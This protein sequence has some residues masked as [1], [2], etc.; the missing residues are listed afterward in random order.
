MDTMSTMSTTSMM[1]MPDTLFK[2]A[3]SR[4]QQSLSLQSAMEAP[5]RGS[6]GAVH[7][8]ARGPVYIDDGAV[9]RVPS[10]LH[11]G[12]GA[13]DRSEEETRALLGGLRPALEARPSRAH[14]RNDCLTQSIRLALED[15][16]IIGPLSID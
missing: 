3:S 15:Q 13:P 14:G 9:Y 4:A 11:M 10:C 6:A 5:W 8:H 16:N 2:A 7:Q 12:R 1:G